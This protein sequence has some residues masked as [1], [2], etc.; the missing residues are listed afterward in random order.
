[1]SLNDNRMPNSLLVSRSLTNLQDVFARLN[2]LQDQ[3]GS[4][5]RLRRPSDAPAD[6]VPALQLHAGINRNDQFARNLDDADNWL[7]AADNA[8]TTASENLTRVRDLVITARNSASDPTS[9]QALANEI[10]S[11]RQG[12]LALANTQ[13]AGRP[14][15]GGTASGGVAYSS[16]GTYVG[17]STPVERTIA[18]GQRIQV[19]VN[20]DAVFGVP[21]DDLFTTLSQISATILSNP[22]GLDA[23]ASELD[24]RIQNVQSTLGEVGARS[25]R[26]EDMKTQN[27]ADG[28]TM[29]QNLSGLEDADLAEVMMSLEAQRVAYQAA[30]QATAK[31]IQPSLA[32]FLR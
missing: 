7:G 14:V 4:L 9:R 22:A 13:Y 3:A 19:N 11:I 6:V 17:I 29:K 32:D 24:G 20:G 1:M 2:D 5:K 27:T 25:K 10:D 30:L 28:L 12:M 23:L 31:A 21:G 8:L 15:F 26:V 18:P 16:N